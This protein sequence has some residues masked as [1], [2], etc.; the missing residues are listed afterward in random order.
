[1]DFSKT[2][3]RC[4]SLGHLMTEPK[5]KAAKDAG[6]LSE[7]A[8]TH[9]IDVYVQNKYG[10]RTD[11]S[12]KYITKGLMVEEDS[13]TLYSRVKKTFFKKNEEHL[14]NEFIKGT[15]DLFTGTEIR[16]AESIIDIKSSWDI[17][18]YFRNYTKGASDLYNWQLQGY[19]ALT[20]AKSAKLAFCLVD[21]PE[22]LIM[23][24]K[25]KLMWQMNAGTE[26]NE[27]YKKA[28]DELDVS[29]IFSDIPMSERVMEFDIERDQDGIEK[30]YS[31]IT[32][33][34][35]F[36]NELENSLNPSLLIAAHDKEVNAVIIE[37]V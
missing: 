25:R 23:D 12:N 29:M 5:S 30:L 4:S 1:M 22:T 26:E 32:K 8:K 14:S 3:F 13:I 37:K 27:D 9:L 10:R 34:R 15:P 35:A 16:K 6:E 18:T 31:K 21:T 11:I 20:G 28:C 33:A 19:M 36:L 17:F 7:G 24:A 2:L